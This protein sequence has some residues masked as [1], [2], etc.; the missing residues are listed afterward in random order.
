MET[1][2]KQPY[3]G[4]QND[5]KSTWPKLLN[6]QKYYKYFLASIW[7]CGGIRARIFG[8]ILYPWMLSLFLKRILQK[9]DLVLRSCSKKVDLKATFR[10]IFF[11]SCLIWNLSTSNKGV[12]KSFSVFKAK[13]SWASINHVPDGRHLWSEWTSWAPVIMG[14]YWNNYPS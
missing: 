6:D 4:S 1:R 12:W 11:W 5:G 13:A 7:S 10:K 2:W 9:C 14:H 8:S 3:W